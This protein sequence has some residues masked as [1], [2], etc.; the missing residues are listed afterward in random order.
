ME[1]YRKIV[2]TYRKYASDFFEKIHITTASHII[3]LTPEM[4]TIEQSN[5]IGFTNSKR[6]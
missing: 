1:L 6:Q 5:I 2:V 4:T 3:N